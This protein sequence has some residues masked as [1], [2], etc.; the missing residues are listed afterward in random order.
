MDLTLEDWSQVHMPRISKGVGYADAVFRHAQTSSEFFGAQI[1]W[2]GNGWTLRF[3][4]GSKF[5]FPEAYYSKNYAQGAATEM[6][7]AQGHRIQLKRS[8]VGNLE[9]LISPSGHRITFKYDVA[10]RIVE[11]DED[12]GYTRKYSYDHGGHL[13]TVFDGAHVFTG[14]NTSVS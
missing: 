13:D 4:D 12:A 5:Y 2:N 14:S 9:E 6:V 7:D 3:R 8:R 1:A 11:A 10:D